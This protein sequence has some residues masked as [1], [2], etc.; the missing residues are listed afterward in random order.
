MFNA[1]NNELRCCN[2]EIG[3]ITDAENFSLSYGMTLRS[4]PIELPIHLRINFLCSL[5]RTLKEFYFT[6]DLIDINDS[7]VRMAEANPDLEVFKLIDQKC[8]Y[9]KQLQLIIMNWEQKE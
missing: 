4:Q 6:S 5:S 7:D 8:Y 9:F 2:P 3:E 1:V